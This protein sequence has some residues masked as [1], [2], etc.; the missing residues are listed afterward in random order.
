M[1]ENNFQQKSKNPKGIIIGL[2][3][4][5]ILAGAFAV[6]QSKKSVKTEENEV[7]KTIKNETNEFDGMSEDS[8]GQSVG[9]EINEDKTPLE[10]NKA[11]I[12][13]EKNVPTATPSSTPS[14]VSEVKTFTVDAKNFS[15]SPS[16]IKVKKGDKVKIVMNNTQGFHDIVIDEFA[17]AKTKQVSSPATD[18]MEFVA[19]KSGTFEYYCSVGKHREMG[20]FG[21]LIV[22]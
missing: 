16:E 18:S 17:N 15:F 3:V 20:M 12:E 7:G 8:M 1:E 10:E 21:K 9:N 11:I 19:D 14:S 2:V 6:S 5:V 4:L 22:Q 13:T